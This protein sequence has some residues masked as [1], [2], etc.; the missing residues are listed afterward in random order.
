MVWMSDAHGAVEYANSHWF[1]YS[2][3]N[4]GEGGPLGWDELLHPED[5]ERSWEAWAK[6]REAATAFEIENRLKGAD[7]SYRWHLVRAVPFRGT[8][9]EIANWFGTCTEIES[10]FDRGVQKGRR[11]CCRGGTGLESCG[12]SGSPN[13]ERL[14]YIVQVNGLDIPTILKNL[15]GRSGATAGSTMRG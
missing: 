10:R 9:H 12:P 14:P 3:L 11:N 6:A 5:Q 4:L 15:T 8:G 13:L 2:G 1:D 7:G